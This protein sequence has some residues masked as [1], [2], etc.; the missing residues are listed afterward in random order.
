VGKALP[1]VQKFTKEGFMQALY[2]VRPSGGGTNC[3]ALFEKARQLGCDTDFYLTDGG[4][5]CGN[6]VAMINQFKA[7]GIAMPK[8]VVIV[9]CGG[10]S[11]EFENAMKAAGL[12]VAVIEEKQLTESALVTQAIKVAAKGAVAIIDEIMETKLLELPKWYES[13]G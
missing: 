2:G 9:K 3:L 5:N 10:Y 6:V 4:H 13:V 7:R 8:Q 12:S 1:K 11:P